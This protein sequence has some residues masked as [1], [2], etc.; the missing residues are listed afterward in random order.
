[1]LSS[2]RTPHLPEPLGIFRA[3]QRPTYDEAVHSQISY[4]ISKQGEGDLD[5]LYNSGDTW[6]VE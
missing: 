5:S 2:M 4:A 1:M 3:V 6:E